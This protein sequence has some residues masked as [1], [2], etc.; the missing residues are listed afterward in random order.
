MEP[1]GDTKPC[2]WCAPFAS[3][4]PAN[5]KAGRRCKE[6]STYRKKTNDHPDDPRLRHPSPARVEERFPD[7]PQRRLDRGSPGGVRW[8]K[9]DDMATSRPV[10]CDGRDADQGLETWP[11]PRI[12]LVGVFP[13]APEIPLRHRQKRR[14]AETIRAEVPDYPARPRQ[15]H[16]RHERRPHPSRGNLRRL[17]DHR[18]TPHKGLRRRH[19]PWR[20]HHHQKAHMKPVDDA[21]FLLA[22]TAAVG[23]LTLA[24]PVAAVAAIGLRVHRNRQ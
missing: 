9:V 6:P 13:A 10:G 18:P 2:W 5:T 20:V 17:Q 1:S 24:L 21:T 23:A 3:A 16:P 8:P 12:R 14:H 7:P 19:R 11:R 15:T 4:C 22:V